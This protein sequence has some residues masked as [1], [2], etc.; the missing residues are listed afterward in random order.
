MKQITLKQFKS[1]ISWLSADEM[2]DMMP[3]KI[4][5]HWRTYYFDTFYNDSWFKSRNCIF[6]ADYNLYYTEYKTKDKLVSERWECRDK[7]YTKMLLRLL[8]NNYL[9]D[10]QLITDEKN[11]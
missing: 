8:E 2:I 3:W 1:L 9:S 5:K 6:P 11:L 10:Y 4:V 7:I